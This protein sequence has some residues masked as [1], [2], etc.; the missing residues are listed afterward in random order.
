MY[1]FTHKLKF[2]SFLIL[3]A[4]I[5]QGCSKDNPISEPILEIET[6]APFE[7][8][9][10]DCP[11]EAEEVNV[12]IT[13]VVL[14]DRDGE[15]ETLTTNSGI[16]N[17]L[18]FTNGIDVLLAYGD[19]NLD[20]LKN[21][22]I[23]LGT[24]NTIVVDG[25]TFPLQLIEDNI[26]K[27]KVD[28]DRLDQI[29]FLVDFFACTSIVQNANGFF[30]KPI[31]KFKGD[32]ENSDEL[33]EELIESFEKCYDIVFPISLVAKGGQTLTANN[34]I[35]LIGI[36]ISNEIEDAVFP[37]NLLDLDGDPVQIN[38]LEEARL[39]DDC[40]LREEEEDELTGLEGLISQLT[41]CYDIV[42]PISLLDQ[43]GNTVNANNIEELIIILETSTI[44][45]VVFPIQLID[46]DGS[47]I[48]INQE[49][50]IVLL[51]LDC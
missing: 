2:F 47:E 46:E 36:I 15:R 32:R 30:L 13:G 51:D 44:D 21:I 45:N 4:F 17:L 27:I 12:E 31:I 40:E 18:E 34:R 43:N 9:L 6:T 20:N 49:V 33:V 26:V 8:Y 5:F 42:F 23:E 41:E 29:Q 37:I 24:Q 14:E 39:I 3:A 7:L 22:Y 1:R 48:N 50:D 11:F 25:E 38:S 10:T 16:F 28:L 35:D 19:I